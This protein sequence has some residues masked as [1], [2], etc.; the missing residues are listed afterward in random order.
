MAARVTAPRADPADIARLA[1]DGIEADAYEIVADDI[2]RQVLATMSGGV[3][4]LYRQ[5]P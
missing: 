1:V 5:L 4:A 3:A 2:C